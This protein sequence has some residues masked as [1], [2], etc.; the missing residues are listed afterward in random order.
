MASKSIV[1]APAKTKANTWFIFRE[2]GHELE[3]KIID[4]KLKSPWH[5]TEEEHQFIKK[6]LLKNG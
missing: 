6:K 2:N 3:L 4:G 1:I 5:L